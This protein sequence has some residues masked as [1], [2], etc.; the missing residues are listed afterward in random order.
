MDNYNRK[1][2]VK[3]SKDRKQ[4][5]H[6]QVVPQ[7]ENR[8]PT[9]QY[10]R[11]DR[12]IWTRSSKTFETAIFAG[13]QTG[14][15]NIHA[16]HRKHSVIIAREW[17]TLPKYADQRPRTGYRKKQVVTRSHS[18]KLITYSRRTALTGLTSTKHS[19]WSRYSQ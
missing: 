3:K 18:Q 8:L 7:T 11:R 6:S 9:N 1:Y 14:H 13:N 2:G 17:D 4:R 15:R 12:I 19:Y 16:R 10:G 5:T